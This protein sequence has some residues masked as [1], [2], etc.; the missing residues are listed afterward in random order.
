[1]SAQKKAITGIAAMLLVG[2]ITM[3]FKDSPVPYGKFIVKE[4]VQ[5]AKNCND[6]VPKKNR[7]AMKME[8][9]E[10][11]Q[12]ELDE[13]LLLVGE[14]MKKVDISKI[15]AEIEKAIKEVDMDKIRNEVDLA[16]KKIDMDKMLAD[17]RSSLK[18]TDNDLMSETI[19]KVLGEAKMEI[20]K[21]KIEI[22]KIDNEKLDQELAK[23]KKDMEKAKMEIEKID[24][25]KIMAE[26][27]EGIDKA[28][29]ELRLTREM[30]NEMEKDG[31]IYSKKGFTIEYKNKTLYIDGKK[32]DEKTAD[33]YRKYFQQ[34]DFKI[35]IDK[36]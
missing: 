4:K 1:M 23:A 6:T 12:T 19:E 13:T 32:Q 3:S 31:L 34:E 28:K 25:D 15:K 20:E 30:F 22:N 26:A 11:L 5:S 9:F 24:M 17:V 16:L 36:D 8:D 27:K 33:K 2:A 7:D 14:E 18:N 10:K 21:A 35:T 29:A